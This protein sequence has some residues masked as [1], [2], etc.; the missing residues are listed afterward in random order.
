MKIVR[1]YL[2]S[3]VCPVG[4]LK[5]V[6]LVV[7]TFLFAF[8]SQ[9]SEAKKFNGLKVHGDHRILEPIVSEIPSNRSGVTRSDVL[10]RVK[11]KMWDL[12]IRPERPREQSHF[13]EIELVILSKGTAFSVEVSLKK[14]AQAYGYDPKVVGSII[15]LNQGKYGMFGNAGRDK[16]YVL[17]VV[18]EV[19]E[20]FIADYKDS[21]L[22]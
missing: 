7:F 19:L 16:S 18:E 8:L 17:D 4:G 6:A 21:N 12:G 14:M 2:S 20:D 10:S 5:L 1:S 11:K 15:T 3:K 13:L 22:E 9:Q